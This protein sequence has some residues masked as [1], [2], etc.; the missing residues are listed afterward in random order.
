MA[1]TCADEVLSRTFVRLSAAY[2][3]LWMWNSDS[4]STTVTFIKLL[5]FRTHNSE[6]KNYIQ[7]IHE[8]G[9]FSLHFFVLPCVIL[10]SSRCRTYVVSNGKIMLSFSILASCIDLT[11]GAFVPPMWTTLHIDNTKAP[12]SND[13]MTD[14][15]WLAREVLEGT[16]RYL[17]RYPVC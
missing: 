5:I 4:C 11:F 10:W 15:W 17:I 13:K 2:V 16:V 14:E 12:K 1:W 8:F 6:H 3:K 7:Q 9:I